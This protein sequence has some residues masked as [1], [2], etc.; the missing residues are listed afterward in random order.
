MSMKKTELDKR[1]ALAIVNAQRQAG[2]RYGPAQ[3]APVDRRAQREADRAAGRVPFAVKL[4]GAL[5]AE[6]QTRAQ[7]D[8]VSLDEATAALL[9]AALDAGG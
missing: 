9:R 5:A 8:G 3:A 2:N 6:V 1:K 7:R 4:P